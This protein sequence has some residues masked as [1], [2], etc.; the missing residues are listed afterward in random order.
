[1][2]IRSL[3]LYASV[4]LSSSA[5]A[6]ATQRIALKNGSTIEGSVVSSSENDVTLSFVVNGRSG[7]MTV[8]RD[9]VDPHSWYVVR[10]AATPDD[11]RAHV[12][13]ARFCSEN[14]LFFQAERE[15]DRALA[16]DASLASA[17]DDELA[18]VRDAAAAKL[19]DMAREALLS[20]DA[21]RA[22]RLVSTVITRYDD[23]SRVEAAHGLLGQ[24]AEVKA[25]VERQTEADRIKELTAAADAFRVK[26][27]SGVTRKAE[28]ARRKNLDA[29]AEQNLS[30]AQGLFDASIRS[31]AQAL[32]DLERVAAKHGNDAEL[33][34]LISELR[35]RIV[36]EAVDVHVSL[37]STCLV[38][39]AF[40]KALTHADNALALDPRSSFARDFRARVEIASAE[41]SRG[42]FAGR[43]LAR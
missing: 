9:Q 19:L 35:G 6:P 27:L 34:R 11:A 5:G 40:T 26:V 22:E 30:R 2:I 4:L 37:G 18:R 16:L 42:R 3:L 15:L 32:K 20:K 23:T 39:G 31:Y 36:E 7:T 10:A 21:S 12:A 43:R 8:P 25:Q 41:A 13:L 29:L 33:A 14:G 28:S 17:V 24:V 38:R 1:M